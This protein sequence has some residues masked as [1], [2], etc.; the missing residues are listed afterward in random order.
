MLVTLSQVLGG[1][2]AGESTLPREGGAKA[3]AKIVR[4]DPR[5][6]A[7][8]VPE[9]SYPPSEEA[10]SQGFDSPE[11]LAW[12][13]LQAAEHGDADILDRLRVDR[14]T[15]RT[16]L[17]PSFEAEK[18]ANT[19]PV[20]TAW[21]L[22]D[23]QSRSGIRDLIAD[24]GGTDLEFRMVTHRRVAEYVVFRLLRHPEVIVRDRETGN[25]DSIELFKDIVEIGGK[26]RLVAYPS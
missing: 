12:V 11:E 9:Y 21:G 24:Y 26:Y 20:E 22:L 15:Y 5:E 1:C 18:I 8:R 16:V 25:E 23:L 7:I 17:W 6:V 19:V 10:L 3:T 4:L 13:A 14:E 2:T